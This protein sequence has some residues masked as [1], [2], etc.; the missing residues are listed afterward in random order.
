MGMALSGMIEP[1]KVIG[2]LDVAGSWDPSLAFVM[3]GALM[4]FMPAY[5]LLVKPKSK[6]FNGQELC[7]PTSKT[8][9]N[10]LISG[11]ALFGLG[12]G[13]AGVC[14]GPAVASLA[15]GNSGIVLFVASMLLGSYAMKVANTKRSKPTKPAEA[16]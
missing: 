14:P 11:A 1:Q 15:L 3:G 6:A 12:W 4:V 10:K 8:I 2:F 9:D 16:V 13:I 7:V 5:F